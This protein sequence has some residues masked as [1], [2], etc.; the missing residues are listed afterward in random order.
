MSYSRYRQ[1]F[2]TYLSGTRS[3]NQIV[4]SLSIEASR[5]YNVYGF[6][7]YQINVGAASTSLEL[8][9]DGVVVATCAYG[10]T[11]AN[12]L[13]I[14]ATTFPILVTGAAA[15]SRLQIVQDGTEG[16]AT[17]R[18]VVILDMETPMRTAA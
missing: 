13:K 12:S 6:Y 11:G 1:N 8:Q 2:T 4:F 9:L 18:Q 7:I 14:S 16:T 15:G 17:V 3:D 10:N 5:S